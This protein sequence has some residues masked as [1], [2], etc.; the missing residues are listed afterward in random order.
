MPR[1]LVIKYAT[2]LCTNLEMPSKTYDTQRNI[3]NIYLVSTDPEKTFP[4]AMRNMAD[5]IPLP[6]LYIYIKGI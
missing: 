3:I 1:H 2:N 6:T 4:L 5:V